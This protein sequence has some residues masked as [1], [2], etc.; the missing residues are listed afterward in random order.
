MD[1]DRKKI[2]IM[3]WDDQFELALCLVDYMKEE[4]KIEIGESQENEII[5]MILAFTEDFSIGDSIH[6]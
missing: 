1:D 3:D 5:E 2:A 4:L 6:D